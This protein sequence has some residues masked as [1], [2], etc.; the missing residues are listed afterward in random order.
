[1]PADLDTSSSCSM[2]SPL[3]EILSLIILSNLENGL[4]FTHRISE[5]AW[6]L[7]SG[8]ASTLMIFSS[9][10]WCLNVEIIQFSKFE[11]KKLKGNINSDYF[12]G[13]LRHTRETCVCVCVCVC[14]T[15][16]GSFKIRLR[17]TRE[18]CVCVCVNHNHMTKNCC[19]IMV[20]P[21]GHFRLQLYIRYPEMTHSCGDQKDQILPK[22]T[23]SLALGQVHLGQIRQSPE[24]LIRSQTRRSH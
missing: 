6:N 12:P 19:Q 15:R 18:T 22:V 13:R 7:V 14:F 16:S 10:L 23:L 20:S 1:M 9:Q 2:L 21:T 3:R 8:L 5:F 4:D 17:H 24:I 11:R